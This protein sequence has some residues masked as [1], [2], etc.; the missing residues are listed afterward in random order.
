MT[1][2]ALTSQVSRAEAKQ[3]EIDAETADVHADEVNVDK[4]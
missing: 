4:N 3:V 2:Q 1:L